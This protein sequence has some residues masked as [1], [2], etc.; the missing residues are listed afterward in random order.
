MEFISQRKQKGLGE[1][2]VQLKYDLQIQSL[3]K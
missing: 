3:E 2:A 1:E